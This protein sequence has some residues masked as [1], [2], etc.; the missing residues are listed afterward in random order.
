MGWACRLAEIGNTKR[1]KARE[2]KRKQLGLFEENPPGVDPLWHY[3]ALF[4]LLQLSQS[5]W[6]AHQHV[7]GLSPE[8]ERPAQFEK[9]LHT[10]GLFGS[11][12]E[13]RFG[14]GGDAGPEHISPRRNWFVWWMEP[15]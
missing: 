7:S 3:F 6:L 11:V 14:S 2:L 12:W 1:A 5:Y 10:Y 8:T 13:F 9:V 15:E 4:R